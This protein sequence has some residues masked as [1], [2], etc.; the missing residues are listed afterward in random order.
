MA[1]NDVSKIL[2]AFEEFA[3]FI[4][5]LCDLWASVEFTNE[6]TSGAP[7]QV[8]NEPRRR[9]IAYLPKQSRKVNLIGNL[10]IVFFKDPLQ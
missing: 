3:C 5:I 7:E 1:C 9:F 4:N 8:R 6:K 10:I 2:T